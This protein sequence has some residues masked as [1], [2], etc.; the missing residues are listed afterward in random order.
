MPIASPRVRA[1]LPKPVDAVVAA[2][3]LWLGAVA[4]GA[5]DLP[6]SEVVHPLLLVACGVALAWRQ[7]YPVFSVSVIGGAMAVH[8]LVFNSM[9]LLAMSSTLLA[10]WT[11]QAHL[12]GPLRWVFLGFFTAGSGMAAGLASVAASPRRDP[13]EHV[14]LVGT[15]LLAVAVVALAGANRRAARS[16]TERALERVALLEAQQDALHRLAAAEERARFARELHDVLGH[17]LAIIAVQA[18]GALLMLERS[19]ERSREALRAMAATSRRGV[20][21]TR[22]LVDVLQNDEDAPTAPVPEPGR[23]PRGT[24]P[25]LFPEIVML[26]ESSGL[27]VRV[28]LDLSQQAMPPSRAALILDTVEEALANVAGHA[29]FVPVRLSCTMAGSGIVLDVENGSVSRGTVPGEVSR[30][31]TGLSGLRKR[32]TAQGATLDAGPCNDGWRVSLTVPR[33]PRQP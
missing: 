16:R 25:G 1:F 11:V 10:V 23:I 21:E 15:V 24:A 9:S 27:P 20:D 29:G 18:E 14:V 26:A 22:A 31:G 2:L 28:T 7:R 33:E 17:T 32:A 30:T 8:A 6:H 3:V 4:P 5:S 19:P 12:N 13:R